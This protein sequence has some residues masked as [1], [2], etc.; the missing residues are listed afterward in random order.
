[1][2]N[3]PTIKS[4]YIWNAMG[5]CCNAA[6]TILLLLITTRILGSFF[7]GILTIA[8]ALA[9]QML[10]VS[11]FETGTY[12]VT[13]GKNKVPLGIHLS[14]KLILVSVSL[15][16]AVVISLI[17]YDFYK[18]LCV[19]IVCIYKIL[20]GASALFFSV[21]QKNDRLDIAGK[22]LSFRTLSII[23]V[24]FITQFVCKSIGMKSDVIFL[25]SVICMAVTSLA[26]ICL[27][28][29]HFVK[30]YTKLSF[31]FK[32][33]DIMSLLFDCAPMFLGT[34][35]LTYIC[36]QPK[37]VIDRLFSEEIQN[38]F[39]IIFIPAAVICLLGFF[40]YKPLL[41]PMTENYANGKTGVFAKTIIRIAIIILGITVFCVGCAYLFGIPVLN[42]V[43]NVEL[44]EYKTAFCI[45][46]LG[47]G[48]YAISMLLYNIISIMRKQKIMLIAYVVSFIISI[49]ITEPMTVAYNVNGATLSY[50]IVNFI[51]AVLL[52]AI[53]VIFLKKTKSN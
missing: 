42:F 15:I 26:F 43:Y 17:K 12:Y 53:V 48:M 32:I 22:S 13:D 28:E 29:L 4:K 41:V 44:S 35:I 3:N 11:N 51:L 21:L 18:S 38:S 30:K 2:K 37:Y 7:G 10:T 16:A 23:A 25:I 34:F 6:S 27:Y 8:L 5:S 40:V 1:M 36:N 24:T 49:A 33:K 14:A 20:E 46:I 52:T 31:S 9:Q 50:L 45:G 47:G 39:G 19:I